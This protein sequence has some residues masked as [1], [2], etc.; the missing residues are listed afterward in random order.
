MVAGAA[1]VLHKVRALS[2]VSDTGIDGTWSTGTGA[3]ET[4]QKY[5]NIVNDTFIVPP[6]AGQSY[7]F[8]PDSDTTGYWEQLVYKYNT[9]GCYEAMLYWQ[10]GNYT[11][12]ANNSITLTPF[13]PDGRQQVSR[14]CDTSTNYVGYYYQPEYMQRYEITTYLH[15]GQYTY[16]LQ[17]YSY[18]GSL[19]PSMYLKYRPA[20]M[21]PTVA[22][23]KNVIGVE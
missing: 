10:H 1:L 23:H 3:V 11:I 20:A 6:L 2:P 8:L 19:K 12:N 9:S 7:S 17:L 13:G 4:G 22:M 5:F 21:Y 16:K 18:D 15:Y 14:P